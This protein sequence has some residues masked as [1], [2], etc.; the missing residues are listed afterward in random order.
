LQPTRPIRRPSGVD[1]RL[2]LTGGDVDRRE[3]VERIG[4]QQQVCSEFG[5]DHFHPSSSRLPIAQSDW[6][7]N[8]MEMRRAREITR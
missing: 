1:A 2:R 5:A 8:P 4:G 3:Q 6:W 7:P